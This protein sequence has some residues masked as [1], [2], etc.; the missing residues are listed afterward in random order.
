MTAKPPKLSTPK[1]L[2]SENRWRAIKIK[3]MTEAQ[4]QILITFDGMALRRTRKNLE[5][6]AN[7]GL[8]RAE[9]VT[10][11]ELLKQRISTAKLALKSI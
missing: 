11:V 6:V 10:Q 9:L 7:N 3:D 5:D 2:N 1:V 8:D 4:L